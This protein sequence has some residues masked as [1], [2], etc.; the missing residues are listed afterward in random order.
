[1]ALSVSPDRHRRLHGRQ[2]VSDPEVHWGPL[3]P[4]VRP[5]CGGGLLLPA[6]GDRA[7]Q[8][9]QAAD[10]GHCRTGEVQVK[11]GW[12]ASLLSRLLVHPQNDIMTFKHKS[13]RSILLFCLFVCACLRVLSFSQIHTTPTLHKLTLH[14]TQTLSQSCWTSPQMGIKGK[15]IEIPQNTSLVMYYIFLIVKKSL[16]NSLKTHQ[17]ATLLHWV[18]CSF[19]MITLRALLLILSQV[20]CTAAVNSS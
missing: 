10:L 6:G 1:M 11:T 18:T 3:C 4:G 8:E 5:D 2:V 15:F 12:F 7:G 20:H 17:W 14:P 13:H 16:E 9:D 19:I